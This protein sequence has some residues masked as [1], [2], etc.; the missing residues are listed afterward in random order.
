[1]AQQ[2]TGPSMHCS[3]IWRDPALT[4]RLLVLVQTTLLIFLVRDE[5]IG[6]T[7]HP[8]GAEDLSL[9]ND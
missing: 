3:C 9:L 5:P 1:L 4:L 7:V 6:N 8:F 2:T